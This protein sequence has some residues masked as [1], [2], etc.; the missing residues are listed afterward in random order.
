MTAVAGALKSTC[1]GVLWK[2]MGQVVDAEGCRV[3]HRAIDVDSVGIMIEIRNGP[4]IPIIC[5][6]RGDKTGN[7]CQNMYTSNFMNRST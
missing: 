3:R 6:C 5:S 7:S 4:V 1:D 2:R